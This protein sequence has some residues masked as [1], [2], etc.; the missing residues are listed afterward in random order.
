M[1][2]LLG[3]ILAIMGLVLFCCILPGRTGYAADEPVIPEGVEVEGIDLSNMTPEEARAALNGFVEDV[4][5][6]TLHLTDS[7]GTVMDI[8]FSQFGVDIADPAVVD[9]LSQ[10]GSGGNILTRYKA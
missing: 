8:P 9:K 2:K 5:G 6:R 1:K 10:I 3:N 7:D 4:K